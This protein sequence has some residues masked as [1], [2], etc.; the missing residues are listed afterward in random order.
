MTEH[1][2]QMGFDVFLKFGRKKFYHKKYCLKDEGKPSVSNGKLDFRY[3]QNKPNKNDLQKTYILDFSDQFLRYLEGPQT[4][5]N[6]NERKVK[7]QSFLE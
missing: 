2:T 7:V 1:T 4:F 3:K 6:K 5:F